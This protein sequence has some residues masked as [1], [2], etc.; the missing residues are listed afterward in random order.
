MPKKVPTIGKPSTNVHFPLPPLPNKMNSSLTP[1]RIPGNRDTMPIEKNL[2]FQRQNIQNVFSYNLHM[3][4]K[5]NK[6]LYNH[7]LPLPRSV[8][9]TKTLYNDGDVLYLHC[10]SHQQPVASGAESVA[11]ILKEFIFKFYFIL[12]NLNLISCMWLVATILDNTELEPPLSPETNLK[13]T[14]NHLEDVA[15]PCLSSRFPF[16]VNSSLKTIRFLSSLPLPITAGGTLVPHPIVSSLD[17]KPRTH[18]FL[19]R[20]S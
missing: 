15:S 13:M 14:P 9:S 20:K 3:G 4:L 1:E 12:I 2:Q 5:K 16:I 10:D 11:S 6:F 19:E 18:F 7:H 17:F 8:L